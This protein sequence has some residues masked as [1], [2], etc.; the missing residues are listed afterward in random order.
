MV[1]PIIIA[2][3]I[4]SRLWPMSSKIMP[5]Q[6]LK[7]NS[8]FSLFQDTLLRISSKKFNKPIIVTNLEY[9]DVINKQLAE[10]NIKA[11][12]IFEE[13]Q[14]NTCPAITTA[15][16]SIEEDSNV[17]V[18]PSDH[19]FEDNH[20]LEN[21]IDD[22][23]KLIKDHILTFGI[24]PSEPS[25]EYGYI[26]VRNS[27]EGLEVDSFIEKP[28]I[29]DAKKY[30]LSKEFFW[31]SGMLLSKKSFLLKK[32]KKHCPDVYNHCDSVKDNNQKRDNATFISSKDM[33]R[34]PSISIDYAVLEKTKRLKFFEIKSN[35]S[36][37]G[38]WNAFFKEGDKDNHGNV[39]IGNVFTKNMSNSL[40]ISE[41]RIV[42]A[43]GLDNI[44]IINS[45][46][47][48]LVSSIDKLHELKFV[49]EIIDQIDTD[50]NIIGL[51]NFRPWGNYVSIFKGPNFQIKLI[52]VN[53]DSKLSVQ[54]HK[55]RSEHWVVING[56]A[57]VEIDGKE[58]SLCKN[59]HCFIPCGSV[60]SLENKHEDAL[61]IL[62]L[63]YGD[64]LGEDD[65]VRYSDIYG[66][67]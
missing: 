44:I 9:K 56:I 64:Y 49:K 11:E 32:I 55:R 50:R 35:W 58:S 38:S 6:F 52:N 33:D 48:L 37:M 1:R 31:N 66:R 21:S 45:K 5:K 14:K 24:K 19:K 54:S 34:C 63:Q 7:I 57:T 20:I 27:D 62:E 51:S 25:S 28:L 47:G 36:D 8:Q 40:I 43:I 18:L 22:A 17:L 15:L 10:V 13:I 30:L 23:A 60:H 61:Q 4:G 29:E 3:G 39:Q 2:G 12:I 65:I 26:K 53:P 59:E 42:S 67:S 46:E 41:D 16:L